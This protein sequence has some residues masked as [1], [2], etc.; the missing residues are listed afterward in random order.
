MTDKVDKKATEDTLGQLHAD[1]AETLSAA[2]KKLD[3]D[4]LPSASI[5]SVARQFLKDN[6]IEVGPGVKAGPLQGLAGLPVFDDD[7]VVPIR[8]VSE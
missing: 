7:N 4:G 3:E 5:L 6:K 1:L 2:L 8:K